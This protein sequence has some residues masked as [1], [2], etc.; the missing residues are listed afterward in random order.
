MLETGIVRLLSWCHWE[1]LRNHH[2]LVRILP[3][4]SESIIL[5][6]ASSVLA[7]V[8]IGFKVSDVLKHTSIVVVDDNVIDSGRNNFLAV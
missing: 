7:F 5:I 8:S 2:H 4:W 1:L 6:P 3:L